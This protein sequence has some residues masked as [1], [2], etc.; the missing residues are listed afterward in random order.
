MTLHEPARTKD[1]GLCCGAGGGRM[2]MEER[3][4][5]RINVERTEELLATGAGAVAVGCPFCMTMNS[6]GVKAVGSVV[7]VFDI[8]EVVAQRLRSVPVS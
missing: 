5:K 7:P 3:T 4:G 8:A 6:D 1:R 2:W